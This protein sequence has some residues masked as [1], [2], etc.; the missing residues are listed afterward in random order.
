LEYYLLRKNDSNV[1]FSRDFL[2][3]GFTLVHE[4]GWFYFSGSSRRMSGGLS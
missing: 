4:N 1:H 3:F 2:F